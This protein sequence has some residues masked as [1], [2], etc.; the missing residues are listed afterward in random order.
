MLFPLNEPRAAAAATAPRATSARRKLHARVV[1]ASQVPLR[2]GQ[3]Q[4]PHRAHND[5]GAP[6]FRERGDRHRVPAR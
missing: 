4:H 2:P 1:C 5:R 3:Q 6:G